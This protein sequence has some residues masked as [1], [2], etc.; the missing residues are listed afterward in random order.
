MLYLFA[1]K[2]KILHNLLEDGCFATSVE[3]GPDGEI[4]PV[5][6]IEDSST[7]TDISI[8]ITLFHASHA[9]QPDKIT[10]DNYLIM[11]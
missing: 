1:T 6:E 9:S 4:E 8:N 11:C 10:K 7:V 2:V 5:A 3:A